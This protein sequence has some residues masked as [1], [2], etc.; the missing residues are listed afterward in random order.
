[1]GIKFLGKLHHHN[2]Y[3]SSLTKVY[4]I[5]CNARSCPCTMRQPALSSPF[6]ETRT[7]GGFG[8][9]KLVVSPNRAC[10]VGERGGEGSDSCPPFLWLR[11]S[12]RGRWKR[13]LKMGEQNHSF[14]GGLSLMRED[15]P[16]GKQKVW[17]PVMV[18]GSGTARASNSPVRGDVHG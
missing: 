9:W 17:G 13:T 3:V 6:R 5:A 18:W 10:L 11:V 7:W 2:T 12:R 4:S 8:A 1:M 15:L 14:V 16:W